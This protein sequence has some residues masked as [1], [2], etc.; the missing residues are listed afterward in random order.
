MF[1]VFSNPSTIVSC[2]RM[3]I[4]NGVTSKESAVSWTTGIV[5]IAL[6]V[7]VG[8]IGVVTSGTGASQIHTFSPEKGL[9]PSAH[10]PGTGDPSSA[11]QG[12][13]PGHSSPPAARMD[14]LLLLLHFQFIS[15]SGF[16]TLNYPP[17]YRVFTTNFAWANFI[18]PIG[19]FRRAAMHMRKCTV[20]TSPPSSSSSLPV[21]DSTLTEESAK[22]GIPAYAAKLGIDEQDIF[23][24][25]YLVF[26]S[27][28]AILI[29]VVFLVTIVLQ[30]CAWQ[31]ED[32]E[33]KKVWRDRR[34]RWQQMSSNNTLRVVGS[35]LRQKKIMRSIDETIFR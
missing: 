35:L 9:G 7:A 15:S 6:L 12:Q 4:S 32:V 10:A 22:S 24:V 27:V 28:C 18:I 17:I 29:V 11:A 25:A 14:P 21:V 19:A 8:L 30:I 23:G 3:D 2:V 26:L 31:A 5:T 20:N 1:L 34:R 13:A 16:L 33:R